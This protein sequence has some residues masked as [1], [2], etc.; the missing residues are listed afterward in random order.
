MRET[1]D[2]KVLRER[3]ALYQLRDGNIE[4]VYTVKIGNRDRNSHRYAI[5]TDTKAIKIVGET[6]VQVES[7]EEISIPI[8]LSLP[9]TEWKRRSFNVQF[10]ACLADTESPLHCIQQNSRFTGPIQ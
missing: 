10:R 1:T 2:V 5:Q 6:S 8:R 7:G 9:A 4:N 3:N